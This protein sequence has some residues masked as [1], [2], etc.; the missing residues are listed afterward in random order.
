MCAGLTLR[1][2]T[3]TAGGKAVVNVGSATDG[4]AVIKTAVDAFGT[5]TILLNNAGILR[6]KG[7]ARHTSS[8]AT[9]SLVDLPCSSSG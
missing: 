9:S 3:G 2:F 5:V 7:Y 6:D 1:V 8:F 4:Q